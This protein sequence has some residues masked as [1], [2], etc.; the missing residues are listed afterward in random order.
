MGTREPVTTAN[1]GTVVKETDGRLT[2]TPAAGFTGADTFQYVV[3]DTGGVVS[4]QT[5]GTRVFG[6]TVIPVG[7]GNPVPA[8]VTVNV[9]GITVNQAVFRPKLLKWSVDGTC[10]AAD[11][12]TISLFAGPTA[13]P[14]AL[15]GTATVAAGSWSFEGKSTLSPAGAR[16]LSTQWKDPATGSLVTGPVVPLAVR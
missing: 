5:A 7:T 15:V 4:G 13:D 1:G 11:G 6:T 14:K 9:V 16:N 8:L 3:Q 12:S 2:Y 10:T